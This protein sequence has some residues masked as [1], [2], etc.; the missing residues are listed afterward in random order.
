MSIDG[1]GVMTIT[2]TVK[3]TFSGNLT[4]D[5]T[6]NASSASKWKDSRTITLSGAV[7]GSVSIDGSKDV[8]L[9]TAVNHNHDSSYLKLTGG[10]VTGATT[11]SDTVVT[12][13]KTS[14]F[15]YSGMG[16]ATT[17]VA[18]PVWFNHA[19][20]TGI[21]VY[22]S[23]FTYNPSTQILT[24]KNLAGNASTA[25]KLATARTLTIGNKGKTFDGSTDVSWTLDE[26][27]ASASGHTHDY[28]PL[29]GGEIN[30]QVTFND[31]IIGEDA[32]LGSLIVNGAGRFVNGLYG[33]L[34]GNVTGNA[35]TA[36]TWENSRT[37]TIGNT[38][39]PV[40]GSSDITW[41]LTEIG[42]SASD[43]THDYLP[44]SGGT[45]TGNLISTSKSTDGRYTYMSGHGFNFVMSNQFAGG[46][47]YRNSDDTIVAAIGYY[48]D[49]YFYC[50]EAYNKP[51]GTFK[52]G[53]FVGDL[54]GTAT[55]ATNV[56][57]TAVTASSYTNW[58]PLI[59][60]ASNSATEGF[61][62]TTTTGALYATDVFGVQ[63]STGTIRAT[64][65]KGNATSSTYS[66]YIHVIP[67]SATTS[68]AYYP[69]WVSGTKADTNYYPRV[70]EYFLY[71]DLAGTSSAVGYANLALGN[72]IA[73]GTAE[74]RHGT[75]KLYAD[76]AYY[77]NLKA[78]SNTTSSHN[79][80]LPDADGTI[81]LTT[82]NVASA[83][84]ATQDASGNVIT[85]KYVAVDTTQTIS[86]AKTFSNVLSVSNTTAST[87][88]S[89]GA[90]KVSGGV[91]VTGQVSAQALNIDDAVSLEYDSSGECLKFVFA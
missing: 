90:L 38:S 36:S 51:N 86:G 80:Y 33:N 70:H 81:A 73:S 19:N 22:N 27:G 14:G 9:D 12:I 67:T 2:G 10:T 48:K 53:T 37:F 13:S 3:S 50:G 28:L 5:V 71:T 30:G 75:L 89:T 18:R 26:I 87:S 31:S 54:N 42:A 76:T 40:N 78:T 68:T 74:N 32:I 6:G 39:K 84:K 35:D 23:N 25:T 20:T 49:N 85:T 77:V 88:K 11:F 24:V 44:L 57:Q 66:T 45:M 16:T 55:N 69:V 83:T 52:A 41:T 72:N 64:T 60:G 63:P 17:D 4:G 56:A 7:T 58:R 34:T 15:I 1:S 91:G 62:P 46:I 29:T 79:I 43:H 61:T 21:P 47:Y 82:S 59:F 8:T 65:F